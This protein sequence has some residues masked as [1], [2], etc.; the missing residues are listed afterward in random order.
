MT[1]E[2]QHQIQ[3]LDRRTVGQLRRL[4]AELFGEACQTA[5]YRSA[6]Q[7]S[8]CRKQLSCERERED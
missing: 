1:A 5:S 7:E 3:E 8:T 2:I 4:Y 6:C